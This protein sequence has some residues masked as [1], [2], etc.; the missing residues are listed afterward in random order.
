M[1]RWKGML[2]FNQRLFTCMKSLQ[3]GM[4]KHEVILSG[5]MKKK[6]KS[7]DDKQT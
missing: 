5:I 2:R 3:V 1:R 4:R 7:Y 6:E